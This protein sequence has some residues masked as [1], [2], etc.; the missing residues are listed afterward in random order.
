MSFGWSVFEILI[1]LYQA[2]L[3]VYFL[4]RCV[5][6]AKNSKWADVL[7]VLCCA[8]FYTL[9]LYF[10]IPVTDS[11][12]AVILLVYLWAVSN[13]RWYVLAFWVAV[14]EA[15]FL[16]TVG[17]G[18]QICQALT[19]APYQLLMEPGMPR[20]VFVL[21]TNF[22]LFLVFFAATRRI[23]NHASP[24]ALPALLY[25]LGTNIA[26]LFAIEMLFSLQ[27]SSA[28]GTDWHIFAAYGALFLCSVFSVFLYH[29]MTSAVQKEN[30][31]QMAL[32]HARLNRQHQ[33]ML[34]AM[35]QENIARQHDFK[36]QLQTIE[37]LVAQG[38][39]ETARAYL[40][41]YE[42]KVSRSEAFLTGSIAV[43][44][45]LTAKRSVCQ[46][47]HIDFQVTTCPLS[48]LPIS[49]VNFCSV[50]GNLLDNAI[51]GVNR[52][53]DAGR[54]RQIRLSFHRV[55]NTFTIRCENTLEESS[56][57][58]CHGGFLTSKNAE[59]V[60]HGL[61][62]RSIEMVAQEAEG[63]ASFEAKDHVFA[64]VVT[65]PYPLE[66]EAQHAAHC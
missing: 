24:L 35:Y 27:I 14:K 36:H 16:A 10:E 54:K 47:D 31:T 55:W 6:I 49:E 11:V 8:G 1:N 2:G 60:P 3:F 46:K 66:K 38:H 34:T 33:Q 15:V 58:P 62:I 20:A 63:F 61:G 29:L 7:C 43:D 40:A 30:Q 52:I 9:Y 51:E 41:E 23:R 18:L 25:F 45:L 59:A 44:A 17:L 56:L 26:I 37:Q 4:K 50:V 13:E 65:I 48:Q 53:T 19:N 28:Q 39:S 57:R 22:A 12:H 64:A 21:S 42:A 32:N 5:P